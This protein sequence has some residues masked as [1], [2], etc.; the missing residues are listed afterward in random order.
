MTIYYLGN[1]DNM[2]SLVKQLASHVPIDFWL[3]SDY[4]LM[5][6]RETAASNFTTSRKT[7]F[8]FKM[9]IFSLRSVFILI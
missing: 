4:K 2:S 3:I 8:N 6:T 5:L 1:Q 9:S 7:K